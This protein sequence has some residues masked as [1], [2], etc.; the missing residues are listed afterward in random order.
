MTIVVGVGVIIEQNGHILLGERIRGDSGPT[1]SLPGGKVNRGESLADC[2]RR[3]TFE[4]TNLEIGGDISLISVTN[5]ILKGDAHSITFGAHCQAYNGHLANKEPHLF[6]QWQWFDLKRLP[7]P[8]F[9][10][11]RS[12]LRAFGHKR[13]FWPDGLEKAQPVQESYLLSRC[14]T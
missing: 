8:L 14:E 9:A 12:V 11:T 6:R 5:D 3:E 4:E 2:A 1:W 13:G 7:A 10:P